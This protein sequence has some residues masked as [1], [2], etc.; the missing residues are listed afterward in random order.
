MNE[1]LLQRFVQFE[2]DF[3]KSLSGLFQAYFRLAVPGFSI[4]S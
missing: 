1:L 2:E 3:H 4:H